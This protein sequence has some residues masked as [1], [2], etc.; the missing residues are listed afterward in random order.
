MHDRAANPEFVALAERFRRA[1]RIELWA[2]LAFIFAVVFLVVCC[3]RAQGLAIR[4]LAIAVFT[5]AL[6][7]WIYCAH[8]VPKML[9]PSCRQDQLRNKLGAFCPECGAR[10]LTTEGWLIAAKCPTCGRIMGRGKRGRLWKI[11]ACSK[12]GQWLDDI[13]F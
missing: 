12:C 5:V 8:R 9:C 3:T 11:H 7:A 4:G 13:G 2:V 1:S 10:G 6:S